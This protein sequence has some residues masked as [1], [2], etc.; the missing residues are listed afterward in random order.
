MSSQASIEIM[1]R[2]GSVA[3]LRQ[4]LSDCNPAFHLD[5]LERVAIIGAA[6]E[7][8]RFAAFCREN[9]IEIAALCDDNPTKVDIDAPGCVVSPHKVLEGEDKD[10]PVVIA[11]HR[12]L[13]AQRRVKDMGFTNV[14]PLALIGVLEPGVFSPHAFYGG[15]LEDLFDNRNRYR[16]LDTLLEDDFSR[17]VLDRVLAYRM[18]LDAEVLEPIV[19]WDLYGPKDL[20]D[21]STDE[22]YVDGGSFDGDSIRLFMDRV[23]GQFERIIGFEP[24]PE[25]FRRLK[26]NFAHDPNVEPVNKGL[27]RREAVLSFDQSGTRASGIVDENEGEAVQIPVVGLDEALRG[28][29]VSYIKMNI[30]GAE[31]E[32]LEGARETISTWRPK[33]A[34]SAYH[35][36]TDL[37]SVPDLIHRLG[38]DYKLYLRQH[39]GGV[40][41]TVV[42]AL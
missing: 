4:A 19:E 16:A 14:A 22:V 2:A 42:Y 37:W 28:D 7:G 20:I 6:E 3:D 8:L 25:T 9:G 38:P 39:D 29:R 30:E 40:I 23:D 27:H 33:L 26:A 35:R 15:W 36:P 41:E 5:G 11:S 10:L 21:Y 24:D 31:L 12:V 17:Q 1:D 34:V 13:K 32:A 18:T